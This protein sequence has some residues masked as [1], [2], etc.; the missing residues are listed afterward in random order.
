MDCR[1]CDDEFDCLSCYDGFYLDGND[2][3]NACAPECAECSGDYDECTACWSNSTLVGDECVCNDGWG[4]DPSWTG[5]C[6]EHCP[7]GTFRDSVNSVCYSDSGADVTANFD[8]GLPSGFSSCHE[9][10]YH[11]ERGAYFDGESFIRFDD[12]LA[13]SDY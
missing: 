6:W 10:T 3:C 12:Y 4:R 13:T 7:T 1:T 5:E 2:N 9:P 8:Q 11:A